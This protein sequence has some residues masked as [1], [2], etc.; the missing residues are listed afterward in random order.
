MT[1][2]KGLAL[3]VALLVLWQLA[4]VLSGMQSDTIAA[5][6][7]IFAALGRALTEPAFWADTGD[8]LAA[9][10]MGLALGFGLGTLSGVLFGLIPPVGRVMRV[11]V[12]LL[13]PLPAIAIL[14]IALLIFGFGYRLEVAIVAFGT[15]FPVLVLT[16][17]AV[18]QIEPRLSEVA[19]ALALSPGARV[20]KIVLPAVLPRLFVALRLAAGI[21]LIIAIT[22]EI[23]ANPIG[24]GARLMQASNSLRPADMYAT[25]FWIGAIGW[26]LNWG[27][28]RLQLWLFPATRGAAQ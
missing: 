7:A 15:C 25:L 24:L 4:V 28:L 2:L 9:G 5:P 22:V 3:P 10:G 20:R 14:P 18:R 16:E 13:R 12:E 26:A 21:G 17:A 19:R 11:T 6:D 27:M 1:A 23:A 8:T